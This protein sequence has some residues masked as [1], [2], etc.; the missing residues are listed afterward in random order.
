MGKNILKIS[1]SQLN[2]TVAAI[3]NNTNKIIEIIDEQKKI[4][5]DLLIFPE[6]CIS[7]YPPTD[8]LLRPSFH[9]KIKMALQEIT[10]ATS[11]LTVIVGYPEQ[12]DGNIFNMAAVISNKKIVHT[13][14]KQALPNYQVF[15]EKRYF[16]SGTNIKEF[17]VGNTKCCLA[18]CEDMWD[19]NFQ[20]KIAALK[21]S[22][23]LSINASPFMIGK[24][25][26][27]QQ[28]ILQAAKKIKTNCI[29][30]N[31]CGA[32]DELAFDGGSFITNSNGKIIAAAPQFSS[33]TYNYTYEI[34]ENRF[35]QL[36]SPKELHELEQIYRA[37]TLGIKDYV[38]KNNIPGVIIG[39]SGGIDSA[40]TLAICH[41]AIGS[42][43]VTALLLP[44]KF[45]SNESLNLA[46]EQANNL[47]IKIKT[48]SIDQIYHTTLKTLNLKDN[49]SLSTQNIQARIRANILM[50]ESNETG[51]LLINTSNRSEIATGFGTLYGDMA[52]AFAALKNIPKTMVYELANWRNSTS[53]IIPN[54]VI[55]REPSAE[56]CAAQKDTDTLPPYPILDEILSLYLDKNYDTD[57]IVKAGFCQEQVV[58]VINMIKKSEFKRQQFAPGVQLTANSFGIARRIAITSGADD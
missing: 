22:I 42:N 6:L 25:K 20:S 21:P 5:S 40:L 16:T 43:R 9:A 49:G 53:Y 15:D 57:T 31:M 52:G 37:L 2:S 23:M 41:D 55:S 11:K 24:P 7:G 48:I 27:R 1:I 12:K 47:N 33:Q 32:Q 35:S 30:T 39:L 46:N 29:Y 4:G 54:E 56:L 34:Q 28:M 14:A 13:Q 50:A 38:Q 19:I 44:S 10:Q 17:Y 51:N 18:I 26:E 58:K 36:N 3:K 45:T 8:L